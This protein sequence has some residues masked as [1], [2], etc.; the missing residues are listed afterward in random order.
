MKKS[1]VLYMS[2]ILSFALSICLFETPIKAE[3]SYKQNDSE[4]RRPACQYIV[5][6]TEVSRTNNPYNI[7]SAV[8]V[9]E[10]PTIQTMTITK[11]RTRTFSG[12]VN[13]SAER[14]AIIAKVGVSL[15]L[16]YWQTN[17]VSI[18][19]ETTVSAFSTYRVDLGSVLLNTTGTISTINEDCSRSN[20]STN[21]K[22]TIGEYIRWYQ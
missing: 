6:Y 2:F 3:F 17:S 18:S 5:S 10:T 21:L 9:N 8:A 19:A 16:G 4:T 20:K 11:T 22:W 1:L 15:E 7:A 13:V 12:N 14:Q